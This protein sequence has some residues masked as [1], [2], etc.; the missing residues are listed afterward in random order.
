MIY[1]QVTEGTEEFFSLP[2]SIVTKVGGPIPE[3]LTPKGPRKPKRLFA[4][5]G[6]LLLMQ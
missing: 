3:H 2:V 5:L 6:R 4:V 1:Q